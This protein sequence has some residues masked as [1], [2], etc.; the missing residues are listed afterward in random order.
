MKNYEAVCVL[1]PQLEEE[2]IDSIIDKLE[3]KIKSAGGEVEKVS[4]WGKKKLAFEFKKFKG[5]EEG[6]YFLI[7]FKGGKEIN[8]E[9][10]RLL[11]IT[12]GV[13]R[14]LIVVAPEAQPPVKEPAEG[15]EVKVELPEV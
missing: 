10:E 14:H 1:N 5:L 12:E 6:Y 2:K 4:R 11:K 8:Q 13:I 3:K 7:N 9:L 15:E